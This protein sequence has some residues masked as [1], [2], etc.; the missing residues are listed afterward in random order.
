MSESVNTTTLNRSS[1]NLALPNDKTII[2]DPSLNNLE[3]SESDIKSHRKSLED[4]YK[5]ESFASS[6]D[7][8]KIV[9]DLKEDKSEDHFSNI[10][11]KF[12]NIVTGSAVSLNGASILTE[13]IANNR[14][15]G[16]IPSFA[17]KLIKPID[18][19][20]LI[21]N[22]AQ[23]SGF[24]L[25]LFKKALDRND[26][27]LLIA[28]LGKLFQVLLAN[29]DDFLL[30]G[31]I[32]AAFDQ[33][34]PA[35]ENIIGR[36]EFRN[37]GHSF[38]EYYKAIKTVLKEV[39]E[40]PIGYL[41]LTPKSGK[42]EQVLVPG[43]LIM[44]GGTFAYMLAGENKILKT[45]ASTFRHI[46]GGVLG[47]DVILTRISENNNLNTSGYFYGGGSF[48]DT[49]STALKEKWGSMGHKFANMMYFLG[50]LFML[51]GV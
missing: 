7:P 36:S 26:G 3:L 1:V 31:G 22:K 35:C 24:G 8:E 23:A 34:K 12:M 30:V 33:L 48:M 6:L 21:A 16:F 29:S 43:S 39:K 2:H 9:Y 28:G 47:G 18:A 40:D 51:K 41:K 5:A 15:S 11:N 14:N 20:A 44:L 27:T 38:K 45:I 50:E 17:K 37:F 49:F 25:G 19:F 46:V 42:V 13:F 32:Q 4:L 10:I